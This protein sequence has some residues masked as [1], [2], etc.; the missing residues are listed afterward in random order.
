MKKFYDP[1]KD[2]PEKLEPVWQMIDIMRR[3]GVRAFE[4][5]NA[6]SSCLCALV[7]ALDP[8]CK[9]YRLLQSLPYGKDSYDE[10]D[11]LDTLARLGYFSRK[12]GLCLKDV[13]ERLFPALFVDTHGTPYVVIAREGDKFKI[14]KD[15]SV[16]YAPIGKI[17]NT[18]GHIII[19]E[20]YDENRPA[21]SKFMRAATNH[22]WF[23]ALLG[24]FHGT[25][26]QILS[27]GLVINII[28]LTTPLMIM[29]IYNRVIGTGSAGVLPMIVTGMIIAACFEI[30][31]RAVRSRGLSWVAARM[32]NIVGNKIFS[33]LLN[34]PP[35]MLERA[36]VSAQLAR[37]RTFESIRDFFSGSVFLSAIEMPFVLIAALAI[38]FIAGPLVLVPLGITALYGILFYVVYKNVRRAIRLAAK[39]TT[40]RQQ[41]TIETFEKIRGIRTFGLAPLWEQKFRDLSGKEMMAHFRLSYLG[42]VGETLGNFLT[43]LSAVM[44]IG[45]GVHMVWAGTLSTG[46]LVAAMILVWRVITPFY[47]ACTMIPRLEQIRHSILQVNMLMDMDTEEQLYKTSSTLGAIK[48]GIEISNVFLKYSGNDDPVLNNVNFSARPGELAVITGENGSG[49]TSLLKLI[50]GLYKPDS[51][52][53]Q[54]DGFDVRQLDA[55]SLRKQIAYLP[56]HHDFFE[57]SLLE[58]L[59]LSNPIASRDDIENALF[60]AAA[61]DDAT[62]LPNGLD[63]IINRH[64]MHIISGDFS[65]RLAL[66]R[67]YLHA[68]PIMLID[69]IPNAALSGESGKNFYKYLQD[70]KGAKTCILISYREDFLTLA[71]MIIHLRRGESAVVGERSKMIDL[72]LEAA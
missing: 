67:L 55:L 4:G 16:Y 50:K 23:Y 48:G 11:I 49:K 9:T 3:S 39:T 21:T 54:I 19:F 42:M 38:Y 17:G 8:R 71:D 35:D 59:R 25:F 63:T 26:A 58:N 72:V 60:M 56:Q 41:F 18:S 44:T 43:V 40:A 31:L 64:D 1:L 14:F 37:I 34:L 29:L 30:V 20:H 52:F 13:D 28:S 7:L 36:P 69:E 2:P 6:W 61:L 22:N 66:A 57:G 32:D 53:I 5:E 27:A 47:S 62:S 24:R 45:F 70:S 65:I 12:L 46:A 15:D 68:A 33:H 51:G 10:M